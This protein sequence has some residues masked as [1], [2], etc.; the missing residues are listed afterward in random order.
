[1]TEKWF[2]LTRR[3]FEKMNSKNHT[4]IK[5]GFTWRWFKEGVLL[6]LNSK[7]ISFCHVLS[8]I[9][10]S[11][12]KQKK[13]S[14]LQIEKSPLLLQHLMHLQE[15]FCTAFWKCCFWKFSVFVFVASFSHSFSFSIHNVYISV[16]QNSRR[17]YFKMK[18]LYLWRA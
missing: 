13:R 16:L 10:I 9:V 17:S 5:A 14:R 1:M 11:G 3:L 12:S 2:S 18:K 15:V 7:V 4:K 6:K 8:Y